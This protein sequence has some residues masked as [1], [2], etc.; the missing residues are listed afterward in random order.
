LRLHQRLIPAAE[1]SWRIGIRTTRHI[2][3][4]LTLFF[5]KILAGNDDDDDAAD[6]NLF[7]FKYNVVLCEKSRMRIMRIMEIPNNHQQTFYFLFF[8]NLGILFFSKLS[9]PSLITTFFC[10]RNSQEQKRKFL[11]ISEPLNK[12]CAMAIL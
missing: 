1:Y 2:S 3:E 10:L 9:H 7:I 12:H 6:C 4:K 5:F 11:F 8:A